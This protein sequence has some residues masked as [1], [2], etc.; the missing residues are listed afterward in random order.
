MQEGSL[1]ST[2]SPSL[3]FVDFLKM[4]ILTGVRWYLIGVLICISL[5]ISDGEQ[6]FMCFLATRMSYLEKCLFRS[7]VHV[8]IG[9]FV[10][11]ILSCMSWLYKSTIGFYILIWY[12]ATWSNS[13]V[14]S[15]SLPVG[16]FCLFD[17]YNHLKMT[18]L[19]FPVQFWYLKNFFL[20]LLH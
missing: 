9:L 18:V 5:I 16:Y 4:P 14:N 12:P 3:L 1:F 19:S 17:I 15:N 11:L 13:F 2:P 6:L 8:W 20:A 7:S 10:S